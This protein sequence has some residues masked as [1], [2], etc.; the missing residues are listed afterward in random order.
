[1]RH[2]LADDHRGRRR[3]TATIETPAAG[4]TWSVGEVITFSGSA[5][6][7]GGGSVPAERPELEADPAPLLGPRAHEL[8]RAPDPDLQ[9]RV[10]QLRRAPTTSTRPT[11]RSSSPPPTAASA[12][13]STRRLDPRTVDL[14]FET[15]PGG[16]QLSVGGEQQTATFT[17]TV[18][19]GSTVSLIAPPRRPPDGKTY[20]FASWSDGGAAAHTVT[21]GTTPAT[22]RA[23]YAEAACTTGREPGGRLGLRR[24]HRAARWRTRPGEATSA[25]SPAPRARTA[26]KFGSALTF[27]GRQR[28][29]DRGR[30]RVA[31]PDATAPPSRP[32][33]TR[34]PWAPTGARCC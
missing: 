6:R 31:R 3:R 8:P 17:R 12:T 11:C 10:G 5:T 13:P 2:R 9:R 26:G 22:Y 14:T 7:S 15:Q 1:M 18:I 16:L 21:A 33:S 28:P 23:N 25:R 27:D 29:G 32:G 24:G 20:E 34:P 4:T 30:Q 19:Q